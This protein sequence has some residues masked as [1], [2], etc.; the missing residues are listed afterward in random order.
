LFVAGVIRNNWQRLEPVRI[1]PKQFTNRALMTTQLVTHALAA[2]FGQ[3]RI[4][5]IKAGKLGFWHHEVAPSV[6]HHPLN[7]AFIVPLAGAAKSILK[8]I[9]RHQFGEHPGSFAFTVTYNASNSNPSVVL[10]DRH[11]DA[12]EGRERRDMRIT[13]RFRRLSRIRLQK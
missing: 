5:I 4:E 10:H 6:S 7:F 3:M 13:E 12:A 8:Q 2:L 1:G 11:R 9:M